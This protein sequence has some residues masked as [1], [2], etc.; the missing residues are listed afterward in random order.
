MSLRLYYVRQSLEIDLMENK[1]KVRNIGV[2][3]GF[4]VSCGMREPLFFCLV[5]WKMWGVR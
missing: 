5:W 2:Y 4:L 3:N 1:K